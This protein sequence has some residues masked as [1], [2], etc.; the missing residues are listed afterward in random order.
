MKRLTMNQVARA[1]LKANQKAYRSLIL[2]IFLSVFLTTAASLLCYGTWLSRQE[3][4]ADR[5]GYIDCFMFGTPEVTDG[6]LQQSGLFSR[7][8]HVFLSAQIQEAGVY[9]GFYDAE[10]SALLHRRCVQGRFPEKAGE[11]AIEQ[12]TL[13]AMRLD[14]RVGDSVTWT[15]H[16]LNGIPEEKTYTLTGILNEQTPYLDVSRNHFDSETAVVMPAALVSPEEPPY[17]VGSYQINRVM[18][19]A[20]FITYSRVDQYCMQHDYLFSVFAVSR[21]GGHA[22]FW[23]PTADDISYALS[24]MAFWLMIGVCLLLAAGIGVSGA[25][26]NILARKTEEIGMLRAVGATRRQIRRLFGRDAWIIALVSLPFGAGAGILAAWLISRLSMEEISFG[27][28]PWLLLPVLG[29][30]AS[31]IFLFSRAPLRRAS[32]RTPMGVLRDTEMLRRAR[33]FRTRKTFRAPRLIAGRQVLLHPFRQAGAAAMIALMLTGAF[34]TVEM[35]LQAA[36][37]AGEEADFILTAHSWTGSILTFSEHTEQKRL[38]AQD[39]QQMAAIP[40][41]EQIRFLQTGEVNLILR[42]EITRYLQDT[43]VVEEEYTFE[44]NGQKRTLTEKVPI[45]VSLLNGSLD[46]L[47]AEEE[48]EENEEQAN[49]PD[50]TSRYYHRMK[51]VQQVAGTDGKLFPIEVMTVDPEDK[52]LRKAVREGAI[53]PEKL[54]TGEEV[55]LYAPDQYVARRLKRKAGEALYFSLPEKETGYEAEWVAENHNDYFHPGQ[56]LEMLQ[57]IDSQPATGSFLYQEEAKNDEWYA[58]MAQ[59]NAS[60]TVGAVLDGNLVLAGM[61]PSENVAILTT[62]SGAEALGIALHNPIRLR[63]TLKGAVDEGEETAIQKQLEQIAMRADMTVFNSIQY[64][65]T[66]RQKIRQ[67]IALFFGIAILF[68]AVSVTMQVGNISRQIRADQRMIG[69]LRA[70]GADRKA[71]LGCYLLPMILASSAGL[72]LGT[73]FYLLIR[74]FGDQMFPA[75]HPEIVLPMFVMLGVLCF[76]CCVTGVRARLGQVLRQSVV[77]NIREL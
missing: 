50:S 23:D 33:K 65:R 56:K 41:V 29:V 42:D 44:S 59:R 45:N 52:T 11:I 39:L 19:Y 18:T 67:F 75:Y 24:Q 63:V 74:H 6:Q 5:V 61:I 4:M 73:A 43:C 76:L 55:L 51:T 20:P 69:T 40:E 21:S 71:L 30:S 26:E 15:M 10:G 31:C 16:P 25:M 58:R 13:E 32:K 46:Y 72:G 64:N 38:T 3:K 1:S 8:G 34:F 22:V 49:D 36:D 53:H 12:S 57:M 7:I 28:S 37:S 9:T 35:G 54:D 17:E 14:L 27:L 47:L 62:R 48:P 77:E 68:F 66:A 2:T 60:A 70:V